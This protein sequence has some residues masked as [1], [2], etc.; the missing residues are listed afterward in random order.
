MKKN[1]RNETIKEICRILA[2]ISGTVL[3]CG[4]FLYIQYDEDNETCLVRDCYDIMKP[5]NELTTK[6]LTDILADLK[7]DFE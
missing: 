6:E 4:R 1:K 7:I 5:L 3:S 2:D